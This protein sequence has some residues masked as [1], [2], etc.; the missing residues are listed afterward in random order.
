MERWRVMLAWRKW[1]LGAKPPAIGVLGRRMTV[2]RG[3]EGALRTDQGL[4]R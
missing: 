2:H 4:T 3:N 1:L